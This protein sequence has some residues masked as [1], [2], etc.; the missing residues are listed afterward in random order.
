MEE[1]QLISAE[2]MTPTL[3]PAGSHDEQVLEMWLYGKASSTQRKYR[4]QVGRLLEYVGKPLREIT[5]AD[6][7]SFAESLV[8]LK[9]N[10]IAR[11][12]AAV[13]S[14][15]TFAHKMGYLAVNV[16]AVF[17][18]PKFK[19]TLNERILSQGQ[20][21]EMIGSTTKQRNKVL[22]RLMY[23]SGARVSEITRLC[24]KDL[25]ERPT[26]NGGGGICT[27][28][29]KGGKT[30]TV[31]LSSD[32]WRVL[33]EW[34]SDTM[35]ANDPVFR[36]NKGGSLS[37]R[38]VLNIVRQAA[39]NAGLKEKPSPHWLRHAF[40][41]ESLS[42]GAPIS[43]VQRDLGHASVATTGKYLHARPSDGAGLYLGV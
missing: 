17:Q 19:D 5:L 10:T 15:L 13:K 36:S 28:Y 38:Q 26:A 41:S 33:M 35:E 22:L 29:G 27:L 4:Q 30:R 7:Q 14:L 16:G 20:V 2:T 6:L 31:L 32:T 18:L 42:R 23:C 40:A 37:E 34:R 8:G 9:A 39:K 43:L 25:V 1:T 11:Y 21:F 3:I 12:M 24:W